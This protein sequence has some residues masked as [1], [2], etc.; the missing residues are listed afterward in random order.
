VCLILV[1]VCVESL[2]NDDEEL[3]KWALQLALYGK[4]HPYGHIDEGTPDLLATFFLLS[5]T[6][7]FE[8]VARSGTTK[9]LMA[10]ELE[11]VVAFYR[12]HYTT[13]TAWVGLT[14]DVSD[15]FVERVKADFAAALPH[16]GTALQGCVLLVLLVLFTICELTSELMMCSSGS[17]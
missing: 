14:G 13:A 5:L 3:G 9:G 8:C 2:L 17:S 7:M 6:Y 1:F 4:S 12:Q 10:L 11:D 16:A 15:D